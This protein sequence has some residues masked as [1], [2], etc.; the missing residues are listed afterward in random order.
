MTKYYL[1][2]NATRRFNVLG[3]IFSF[4]VVE[5]FGGSWIG[6]LQLDD[7]GAQ[8]ALATFAARTGISEITEDEYNAQI[9]KKTPSI[10]YS[11]SSLQPPPPHLQLAPGAAAVVINPTRPLTVKPI[12]APEKTLIG[13]DEAV[14]IGEAPYVD[15]LDEKTSSPKRRSKRVAP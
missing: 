5:Q 10:V 9:K 6:V 1:Y 12:T 14:I 13:V 4:D 2:A 15:V 7:A 3:Y 8:D 11:K